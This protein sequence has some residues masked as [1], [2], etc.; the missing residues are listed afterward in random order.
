MINKVFDKREKEMRKCGM[1][2]QEV[3]KEA[4]GE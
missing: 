1:R 2:L 3:E 4:F